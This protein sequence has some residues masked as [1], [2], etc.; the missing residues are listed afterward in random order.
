LGTDADCLESVAGVV[1]VFVSVVDLDSA[2]KSTAKL[3]LFLAL[4]R[5]LRSVVFLF[6][7][8]SIAQ[9]SV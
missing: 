2:G 8:S 9:N 5:E 6:N 3:I 1:G 7:I 4:G